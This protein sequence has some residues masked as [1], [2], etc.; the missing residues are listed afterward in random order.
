MTHRFHV[1]LGLLGLLGSLSVLGA[2]C[3]G[4]NWQAGPGVLVSNREVGAALGDPIDERAEDRFDPASVPVFDPPKSV[5]PCCPFGKDLKLKLGAARVP[6]FEKGNMVSIPDLGH[7][8]Y[9]NGTLTIQGAGRGVVVEHNGLI[10]SCRGGFIDVAHIRDNADMTLFLS[11]RLARSLPGDAIID[12]PPEGAERRVYVK[13]LPRGFLARYGRW[14]VVTALAEWIQF[15]LSIWHEIATWYGWEE[16]KGFSEKLSAFSLEDLY[17]NALGARIAGG[18]I[19]SQGAHSRDEYDRSMDAWIQAALLRL[20][21]VSREQGREAMDAVDHLWWDSSKALPD[22]TLVTHRNVN[23]TPPLSPWLVTQAPLQGPARE[24]MQRMCAH[25]PAPLELDIP[26]GIG[27]VRFE[28]L[29]KI[30]LT[31]KDWLPDHFPIPVQ[32]GRTIT[33]ADFPA[34]M[35]GIKR[36]GAQELGAGFGRP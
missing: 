10:Y 33:Q 31:F 17:S 15:R 16:V 35:A 26:E 1:A 36:E 22:N 7:H 8:E 27:D 3:R 12:L 6:G 24:A 2:G 19:R 28:D 11:M 13:A 21:A 34:I 23:V 29:V 5:R 18:I 14:R 30:E 4:P 32:K 25:A 20:S 9:D